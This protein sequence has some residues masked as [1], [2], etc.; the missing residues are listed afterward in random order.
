MF[1]HVEIQQMYKTKSI[2][3]FAPFSLET[4]KQDNEDALLVFFGI[5]FLF[6][7]T[8]LLRLKFTSCRQAIYSLSHQYPLDKRLSE[9]S[10]FLSISFNFKDLCVVLGWL[11]RSENFQRLHKSLGYLKEFQLNELK[12]ENS[13]ITLRSSY[14]MPILEISIRK[15]SGYSA[16]ITLNKRVFFNCLTDSCIETA[17]FIQEFYNFLQ[18][19]GIRGK[20]P[21]YL[22][23]LCLE[24]YRHINNKKTE[25]NFKS[26]FTFP[27]RNT[28]RKAFLKYTTLFLE[29]F[30]QKGKCESFGFD[31]KIFF[32]TTSSFFTALGT[33]FKKYLSLNLHIKY[34][35]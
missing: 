2:L 23:P 32:T 11:P 24:L 15:K 31:G 7:K 28:Y 22:F 16:C 17:G 19:C 3:L 21:K 6:F 8:K 33:S 5:Y 4:E 35:N 1:N 29:F 9:D 10:P 30:I 25:I 13:D 12:K 20:C 27:N 26:F 34:N 14:L 18:Q